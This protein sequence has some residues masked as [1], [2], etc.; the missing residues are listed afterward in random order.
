MNTP[1]ILYRASPAHMADL[2]KAACDFWFPLVDAYSQA[3]I[4][5]TDDV[6][7]AAEIFSAAIMRV[8]PAA[9]AAAERRAKGE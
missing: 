1:E 8:P 4:R 5:R 7:L 9:R 6:E 2:W 3:A